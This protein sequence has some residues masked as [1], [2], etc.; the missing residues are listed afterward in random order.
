M[1]EA[2]FSEYFYP[3]LELDSITVMTIQ[4]QDFNYTCS[5]AVTETFAVSGPAPCAAGERGAL[6]YAFMSLC[7]LRIVYAFSICM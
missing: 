3:W 7:A 2:D 1:A 6:T 5:S 4:G